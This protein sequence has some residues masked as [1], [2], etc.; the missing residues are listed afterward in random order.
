MEEQYT[1]AITIGELA[2][3]AE[4]AGRP[5]LYERSMQLMSSARILPLDQAA[6]EQYGR[7]R[8]DLERQGRRLADPDLRIAA[9]VLAHRGILISG[10]LRHFSR[11]PG[12]SVEDWLNA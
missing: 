10:N 11:V 3:G 7:I 2:Y 6:A 5:D 4:R 9:I 8:A 12:L 1:T